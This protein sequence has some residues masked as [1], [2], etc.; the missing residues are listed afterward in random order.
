MLAGQFPPACERIAPSGPV[1]RQVLAAR[2]S[3]FGTLVLLKAKGRGDDVAPMQGGFLP[4]CGEVQAISG[5]LQRTY[6]KS[7]RGCSEG[8]DEWTKA[9]GK[10]SS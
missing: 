3:T 7:M 8:D 5:V 6:L 9:L 1:S 2:A 10:L 4:L